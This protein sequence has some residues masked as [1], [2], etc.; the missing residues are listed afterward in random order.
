M[1]QPLALIGSILGADPKEIVDRALHPVRGRK[2]IGH[3]GK[4]FVAEGQRNHQEPRLH[5]E[6]SVHGKPLRPIGVVGAPQRDE[7]PALVAN[8]LAG[9]PPL[10]RVDAP[11]PHRDR[12]GQLIQFK[13]KIL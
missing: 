2:D 5:R 7:P 9:D 11:V 3:I 6:R 12:P 8:L 10:L 1:A 13:L 4:T